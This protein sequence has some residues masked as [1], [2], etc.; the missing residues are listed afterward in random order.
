M[1]K[2]FV[3]KFNTI[4]NAYKTKAE[5]FSKIADPI[6]QKRMEQESTA[7]FEKLYELFKR[8]ISALPEEAKTRVHSVFEQK[9]MEFFG[10]DRYQ[11][12]VIPSL[13]N[14]MQYPTPESKKY[15]LFY[16][17][18]Q[19]FI[20]S[21]SAQS[22]VEQAVEHL[23]DN[24]L[25]GLMNEID[26]FQSDVIDNIKIEFF[27][28]SVE[29]LKK[30]NK[31]NI[32]DEKKLNE[33]NEE[34][35]T[36]ARTVITSTRRYASSQGE[37][38]DAL[39]R[40]K[41]EDIIDELN[42]KA[43]SRQ[44]FKYLREYFE[45]DRTG[46]Y[47][48]TR[49]ISKAHIDDTKMAEVFTAD[50]VK[51]TFTEDTKKSILKV[52]DYMKNNQM[53]R[54]DRD[55]GEQG[56]KE[57]GFAAIC[58]AHDNLANVIKGTDVEQIRKARERYELEV[59]RMRGLY[60]L[61]RQEFKPVVEMM[62]GNVNTYRAEKVPNEFKNDLLLNSLVSGFFNLHGA[63]TQQKCTVEQMFENPGKI[64]MK[65]ISGF[66]TDVMANKRVE[67]KSIAQAIKTL[68]EA[69]PEKFPALGIARNIEFLQAI[70]YHSE[71]FEKN[72]LSSMLF[73]SY[74]THVGNIA[75]DTEGNSMAATDYLRVN[76][77]DTLANVFLVN[78]E[79][80]DYNKLRA[81]NS[82]SID[83]TETV[84]AFDTIK[85]LETHTVDVSEMIN[86]M[87]TTVTEL[88]KEDKIQRGDRVTKY[89]TIAQTIRAAQFAA[90]QFLMVHPTPDEFD[91]D[92]TDEQ[93]RAEIINENRQKWEELR[94]IMTEPEVVFKDQID[95][96][97][98]EAL[99]KRPPKHSMLDKAAKAELK[100]IRI[101]ERNAEREFAK[102]L[103]VYRNNYKK[104]AKKF[105]T[106]VGE[107]YDKFRDDYAKAERELNSCESQ[108]IKRL[109]YAC[110]EGRI[111]V[112]Y[113][114]QRRRDIRL[115]TVNNFIPFDA[116]EY[117][118]IARGEARAAEQAYKKDTASLIK[119]I[120]K[121]SKELGNGNKQVEK[122]Y[123]ELEAK[124]NEKKEAELKRLD[125]AYAEGKLTKSYYD[126]RRFNVE[127]NN[128][129]KIVPF[130]MDD[131]PTAEQFAL[132]YQEELD[133]K[134]LDNEDVTMLYERMMERMRFDD[135]KFKQTVSGS[136]PK[137][138]LQV[139]E[140]AT[141]N[142]S[143]VKAGTQI[144]IP[145]AREDYSGPKSP[146]IIA[147]NEKS[148]SKQFI[149]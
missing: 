90:Y 35:E 115:G 144:S 40:R 58:E 102:K 70:T 91:L 26:A 138:E 123:A 8:L 88:S 6:E 106:G 9:Y 72:S 3:E 128:L 1:R 135:F 78:D 126:E 97:T 12:I 16:S 104:I 74:V 21:G 93:K 42:E 146:E 55:V 120:N 139:S 94:Q 119:K 22:V 108:E 52:F 20:K 47:R 59:A 75:F 84:P 121:L 14:A 17:P 136:I 105:G 43:L 34:L 80:R 130:G 51:L 33:L 4:F 45:V 147:Q 82:L 30:N 15:H 66:S 73:T 98:K 61:I 24:T 148:I 145:E 114:E 27:R 10:V 64:F 137:P 131:A 86:R 50:N 143:P 18:P 79:D 48:G 76:A 60:D 127:T 124:L 41:A 142:M 62:I 100:A 68:Y 2:E 67:G 5:E 46:I 49:S 133:N 113:Y 65:V 110:E 19:T 99:D 101:E 32:K 134:D 77:V 29:Q 11:K 125:K 39:Y 141:Q 112:S 37:A 57:Y 92:I 95:E 25:Q 31:E 140:L 7:N 44:E 36:V 103:A 83:C 117:M 53:L 23:D 96:K 111:P 63:L 149:N 69:S 81:V 89:T 122:K 116:D 38:Y 28:E 54:D 107:K 129:E 109:E 56:N 85:Y 87:K 118:D 71:T 13:N 132:Q